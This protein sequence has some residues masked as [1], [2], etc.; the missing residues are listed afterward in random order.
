MN[1]ADHFTRAKYR[2]EPG[3]SG[4]RVIG[5]ILG[6]Q[7]GRTLEI[8]NSVEA[9]FT[10]EAGDPNVNA[11]TIDER[12]IEGRVASYKEMFPDLDAVGWYSVKG[13]STSEAASDK[14]TPQD[15]Q[16]MKSVIAKLCDNPI[17]L[18]MNPQS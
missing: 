8:M 7:D 3:N 13:T 12:Y 6:R 11:I 16:V 2:Q 15:I 4:Y 17:F 10:Q 18:L 1:I 9:T 5:C 14:P